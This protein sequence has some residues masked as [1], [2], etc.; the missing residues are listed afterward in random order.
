[1]DQLELCACRLTY[2]IYLRIRGES[3]VSSNGLGILKALIK[4]SR[5][6]GTY[7]TILSVCH[8]IIICFQLS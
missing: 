1:M 2:Q 7:D 5:T 3:E 4:F 8:I 6:D